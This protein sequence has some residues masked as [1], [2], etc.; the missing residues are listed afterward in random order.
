MSGFRL[1]VGSYL[2]RI[3]YEGAVTPS[4]GV[5]AAISL[6]H[7]R[8]VP[9]ENLDIVPLGRPIQLEPEA[10]FAKIVG[11]R[12]GGF[13]F[14]L[15][16]LLSLMLEAI[17][18]RVERLAAQ[19]PNDGG[20]RHPRDHLML[21]VTATAGDERGPA[22][23]RWLTD[24]GA[25][26]TSLASPADFPAEIGVGAE[27]PP[28]PADGSVYRVER[29]RAFVHL[30]RRLPGAEW[31]EENRIDPTP[32][33]LDDFRERCRELQMP[34]MSIF[35]SGSICSHLTADGRVTIRDGRLIVT[36]GGVRTEQP[37]PDAAA[38]RA[39]LSEH[40]DIDLGLGVGMEG[41]IA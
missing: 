41:A 7:L 28:D 13:C 26:A 2:R 30:W 22:G 36:T 39:A 3:G 14:E 31:V 27:T 5:L 40:F 38:I 11:K 19:F 24:V 18:F 1:D 25:G 35:T 23:S 37:L 33:R 29:S 9:F 20:Y 10:L 17:G 8:A 4:P 16:G 15:N 6:A 34:G 32:M 21:A 12:R